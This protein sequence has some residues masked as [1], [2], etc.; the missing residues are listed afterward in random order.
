MGSRDTGGVGGHSGGGFSAGS[1][2][3]SSCWDPVGGGGLGLPWGSGRA[4]ETKGGGSWLGRRWHLGMGVCDVPTGKTSPSGVVFGGG[5]G[6]RRLGSV[7]WRGGGGGG[8]LPNCPLGAAAAPA[9]RPVSGAAPP[10]VWVPALALSFRGA[11]PSGA[12]EAPP[13]T[14]GPQRQAAA[15]RDAVSSPPSPP[16]PP[17][18]PPH[19]PPPCSGVPMSSCVPGAAPCH[20]VPCWAPVLCP[21]L[22]GGFSLAFGTFCVF[23]GPSSPTAGCTPLPIPASFVCAP[24]QL[25]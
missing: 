11:D 14:H 6:G 17:P 15:C 18:S 12:G 10:R 4:G 8:G 22:K 19:P 21:L 7:E 5:G 3:W 13:R 9:P 20:P 1:G 2:G 25:D 16:H 23:W 24:T